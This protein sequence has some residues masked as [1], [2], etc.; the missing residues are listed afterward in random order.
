MALLVDASPLLALMDHSERR[1]A[2]CLELLET[3]PGTLFVP[4]TVV[5]EVS[6]LAADRLGTAAEVRFLNDLAAGTLIDADVVPSDWQRIAELVWTYRDMPLGTTDASIVAIAERLG[7]TQIATLD[8]RH[9]A[10]VQPAHC[11][12]F[13]LLP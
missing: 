1:H 12:A 7:V 3:W 4:Q 13:E 5:A 8:H 9:F 10:T 11:E 2:R 6:Y